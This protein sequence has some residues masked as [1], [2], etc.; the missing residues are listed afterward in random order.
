MLRRL[1]VSQRQLHLGF[2]ALGLD[3]EHRRGIHTGGSSA[4]SVARAGEM[5]N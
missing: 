3:A 5:S 4:S 1:H 2:E